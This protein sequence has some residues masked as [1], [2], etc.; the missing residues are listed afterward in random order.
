VTGYT[1]TELQEMAASDFHSYML[2]AHFDLSRVKSA[3]NSRQLATK[4]AP[5]TMKAYYEKLKTETDFIKQYSMNTV[6]HMYNEKVF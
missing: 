1:K 3:L 2:S 4:A 6:Y 5:G